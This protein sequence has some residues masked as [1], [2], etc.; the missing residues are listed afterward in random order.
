MCAAVWFCKK[1]QAEQHAEQQNRQRK[2]DAIS[3]NSSD[4]I[5]DYNQDHMIPVLCTNPMCCVFG[6]CTHYSNVGE[7]C[8]CCYN[9]CTCGV[10]YPRHLENKNWH[11]QY[12]NEDELPAI[13]VNKITIDDWVA[14]CER[15]NIN[16]DT[17][18]REYDSD[19][20]SLF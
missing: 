16:I 3:D 18:Q 20:D 1:Q 14:I 6:Q 15:Y 7:F 8:Y 19:C 9:K 2:E 13:F 11:N 10:T 12:L 5:I 4:I 17:E